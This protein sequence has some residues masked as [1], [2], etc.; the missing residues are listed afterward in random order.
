MRRRG[1]EEVLEQD[2]EL[3]AAEAGDGVGRS[4]RG[5][6]ALGRQPDQLI[7]ALVPEAVVDQLEV[8]EVDHQHADRPAPAFQRGASATLEQR[9]VGHAG[10]GVG[11]RLA[12]GS[13]A[14]RAAPRPSG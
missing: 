4:R 6:D 10:Q 2:R 13:R 14:A 1:H 11:E 9:A 7:A 3:V 8:V 12:L 5:A